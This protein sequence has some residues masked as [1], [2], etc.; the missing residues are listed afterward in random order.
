MKSYDKIKKLYFQQLKN[1]F[2]EPMK[3][4][5]EQLE[6]NKMISMEEEKLKLLGVTEKDLDNCYEQVK[7]EITLFLNSYAKVNNLAKE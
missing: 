4:L 1:E 5:N 6:I 3:L 7:E 2:Y